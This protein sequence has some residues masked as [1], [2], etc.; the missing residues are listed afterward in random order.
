M[1]KSRGLRLVANNKSLQ[2]K[3]EITLDSYKNLKGVYLVRQK[4]ILSFDKYYDYLYTINKNYIVFKGTYVNGR[5][6]GDGKEFYFNK[7]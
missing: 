5:K 4:D 3:L 2:K 1:T 6:E 7:R